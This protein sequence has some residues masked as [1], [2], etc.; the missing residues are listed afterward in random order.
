MLRLLELMLLRQMR[1]LA[2]S[3]EMKFEEFQRRMMALE[4]A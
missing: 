3:L 2:R 1:E 4:T